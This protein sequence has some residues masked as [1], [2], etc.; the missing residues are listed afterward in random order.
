MDAVQRHGADL[1]LLP[2]VRARHGVGH[3][4]L[5]VLRQLHHQPGVLRTV[6]RHVQKDIQEP[7]AVPV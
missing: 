1:H 6:Q 7:A 5:V 4:L 2:V 3:R